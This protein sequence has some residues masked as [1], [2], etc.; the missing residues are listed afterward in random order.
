MS[1][2]SC[3]PAPPAALSREGLG[4][5]PGLDVLTS[6]VPSGRFDSPVDARHVLCLHVGAPVPVSYRAGRA[7]RQGVRLHGQFCV[8]PGGS[9]TRWTLSQPAT[10]LLLRLS[11]ALLR[12]TAEA[13]GVGAQDAALVPSIHIRDPRIESI[14]WMM[15]AEERDAYPGGRL[16]ADSLAAALAARLLALQSHASAPPPEAR[17]ALPPWRLRRVLEYVE[18]NLDQD[19]TLAE[20]AGVAGF[21][22]SHFKA[23]FRNAVGKPMHRYVLERRVER[24]RVLLCEGHKSVTEVALEAGFAHPSHLARCLRRVLG[25]TP[26]QLRG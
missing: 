6:P 9:S 21:S 26:S 1:R 11:P 3:Y 16:F 14:G 8:V 5:L 7:E 25:V 15:Q 17:R 19:L 24:A 20:L 12:D 22:A 10:S 13:M 23:L 2:P 18:A 4:D